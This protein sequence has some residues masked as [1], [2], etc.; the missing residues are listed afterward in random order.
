MT[1][2][3]KLD[4]A[5]KGIEMETTHGWEEVLLVLK[6]AREIVAMHEEMKRWIRAAIGADE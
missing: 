3:M 4:R 1:I 6:E 2:L 5:I